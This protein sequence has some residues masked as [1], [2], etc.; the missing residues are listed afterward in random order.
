LIDAIVWGGLAASPLLVRAA[1]AI[2][3]PVGRRALGLIM[4]FG[5]GVLISAV[6]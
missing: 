6:A 3:R 2:L 1:V 5:S 4:A